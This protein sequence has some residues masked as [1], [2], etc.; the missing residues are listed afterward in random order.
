MASAGLIPVLA[1]SSRGPE[2]PYPEQMSWSRVSVVAARGHGRAAR[3]HRRPRRHRRH[4]GR[5]GRRGHRPG[6]GTSGLGPR[7]LR[8]PATPG[9]GRRGTPLVARARGV[10]GGRSGGVVPGAGHPGRPA[11]LGVAGGVPQRGRLV[12]P[13]PRRA[14]PAALPRRV[15]AEPAV[16]VGAGRARGLHRTHPARRRLRDHPV[17]SA[18]AGAGAPLRHAS[19]LV[20]GDRAGGVRRDARPGAGVRGVADPA[21]PTLGLAPSVRRSSGSPWPGSRCRRTR[22]SA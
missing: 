18:A 21:L 22:C 8:Q 4:H 14:A 6:G 9:R 2:P 15:A 11:G 7:H 1:R 10:R 3:P 17:P 19:P 20:R 12:G 13:R 5:L 16:A